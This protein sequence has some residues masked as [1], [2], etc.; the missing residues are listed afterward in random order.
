MAE[1]P[2]RTLAGLGRDEGASGTLAIFREQDALWA[3]RH[4]P[5]E[6][7][8]RVMPFQGGARASARTNGSKDLLQG[9]V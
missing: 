3:L 1:P 2:T 9:E 8:A 5:I 6:G 7:E 4:G